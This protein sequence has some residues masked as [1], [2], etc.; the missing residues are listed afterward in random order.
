MRILNKEETKLIDTFVALLKSHSVFTQ[1]EY[2]RDVTYNDKSI[3]YKEEQD[4]MKVLE[5]YTGVPIY[6]LIS[7]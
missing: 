2:N 3:G 5:E 1:R 6:D 4:S 7:E